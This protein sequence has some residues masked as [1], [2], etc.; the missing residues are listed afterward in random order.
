MTGIQRAERVGLTVSAALLVFACGGDDRPVGGGGSIQ[1]AVSPTT[2][3]VPQGGSGSTTVSLSR[4]GGFVGDVTLDV[5]GLPTG[6]T[7]TVTPPRL[8]GTAV[9]AEL[10]LVV[11]ADVALGTH[12]ATITATG[13]GVDQASTTY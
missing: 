8:S 13:H 2:I 4:I 6:I 9:S 7:T 5:T 3:T 10:D 12:T 1:V 11:A